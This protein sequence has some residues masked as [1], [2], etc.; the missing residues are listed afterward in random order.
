MNKFH[1]QT[2]TGVRFVCLAALLLSISAQARP[3]RPGMMP[4]GS[5]NSCA[6]CHINPGGGGART[7]FGND[8][9]AIVKGSSATP[10]W[11]PA[12]AKKDS[13]GDGFTN[14]Q[15][16]G[17]P[18]GTGTAYPGAQVSNPGALSSKPV[19]KSPTIA[20][21]S[22][23]DGLVAPPPWNGTLQA[24]ATANAGAITKVEFYDGTTSLGTI[25][26][27]PF[28][29]DTTL[30]V[31]GAHTL[32]AIAT[33]YLGFA[34]TSSPVVVTLNNPPSPLHIANIQDNGVAVTIGWE[35]GVGPYLLQKK[36]SLNE[37]GW[38]NLLT[39]RSLY[40][41]LPKRRRRRF[42]SNPGPA[43]ECRYSLVGEVIRRGT[44]SSS[45]H[46]RYR[47]R[48]FGHRWHGFILSYNLFKVVR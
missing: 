5:V 27:A 39:T 42:L 7:P 21:A 44:G 2:R 13:D 18:E 31:A 16:L 4:N 32:T 20:I 6:N 47:I 14:G 34:K 1:S 35:G 8:V 30:N 43:D 3:F 9:Y 41:T 15:E 23:V 38:F 22:P 19:E 29:L 24:N 12:L 37:E 33:D 40:V 10:F 25:T 36:A 28:S 17:D 26:N 46:A 45:D 11:S 48:Q